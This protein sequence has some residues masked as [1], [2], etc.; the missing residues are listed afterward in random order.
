M[1]RKGLSEADQRR[2]VA[3]RLRVL[4]HH[5]QVTRN[6][7]KTCRHFG[8]SRGTFY[9]WKARYEKSGR[10][11]LRIGKRG[12]KV[13]P[14]RTP[15]DIEALILRIRQ[16]RQYGAVRISLFLKRYHGVYVSP[17]PILRIL[18]EHQVRPV[19]L[20]RYRPGPSKRRH[21]Y[22]PGQSVQV[23]VKH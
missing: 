16:E 17:A 18:R 21:I 12:P 3:L 22:V 6:V 5:Q 2:Q 13:S 9:D 14:F 10:S 15:P 23:D 4:Q 7:S 8:I 19:S 20:K 11:G 1:P